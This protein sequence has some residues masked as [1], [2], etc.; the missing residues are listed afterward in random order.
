LFDLWPLAAIGCRRNPRKGQPMI[1]WI[2]R[3][4]RRHRAWNPQRA[5]RPDPSCDRDWRVKQNDYI[6]RLNRQG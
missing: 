4:I 6:N 3:L 1:A 2:K 5:M